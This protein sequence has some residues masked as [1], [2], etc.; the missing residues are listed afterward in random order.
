MPRSGSPPQ[1]TVEEDAAPQRRMPLVPA[2]PPPHMWGVTTSQVPSATQAS[3]AQLPV[4]RPEAT[5]DRPD[6]G[7]GG[8]EGGGSGAVWHGGSSSAQQRTAWLMASSQ[9]CGVHRHAA[10]AHSSG[11]ASLPRWLPPCAVRWPAAQ[12]SDDQTCSASSISYSEY[13][14][15]ETFKLTD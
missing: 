11:Q 5:L 6:G 14:F 13:V 9:H 7:G 15:K 1:P 3:K 10:T 12:V 4:S 8:G 2:H